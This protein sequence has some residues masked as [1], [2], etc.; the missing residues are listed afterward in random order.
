M[1][2]LVRIDQPPVPSAEGKAFRLWDVRAILSLFSARGVGSK[3][4]DTAGKLLIQIAAVFLA[5]LIA[6]KLGQATTN[7]R[8]SN[9]GPVWP[10]YG[11]ALAA[12]LAYGYRVW[13]G[14]AASAFLV[15]FA[16]GVTPLA[17][18]GQAIGATVAALT[19]ASLLR[20]IPD[21]DPSLLRLTDAL[22]LVVLGAFG[23]SI[24]SA[25][26]GVFSLYATHVQ[27]YSGLPSAWLIYWLGDSTGVLLVTPLVFTLPTLFG[28]RSRAH[29][30]ELA[31][32]ITLLTA[33]C[34]IVFGDLDVFP[35]RLH[36]LAFAVL[37]FVM[38][39]AI[40]F[41]IAGASLS[42]FLIATIATIATAY[43]FGPFAQSSSFSNAVLLDVLFAVLSVSGLVLG[44][45]IAERERAKSDREQLIRE[46]TAVETRVRLA[47]IIDSSHD[48]IFSKD[49]DGIVL[50]WNSAAQR[51]FGF[52]EAE[53]VGQP[54]AILLPPELED[55]E[56]RLFQR[57]RAGERIDRYK[58]M[59][60]TKA[61]RT[62][63]VSLTLTPL[64]DS[65]GR[66]VAVAEIARDVTEQDLAERAV[67]TLS[68]RLINAQEQERA[69]IA[70]ELH[71]DIGQR[72]ALLAIEL[73]RFSEAAP[74][75]LH[76]QVTHLKDQ[77]VGI[78]T[79]IQALA[80]ELHSSKLELLGI[81]TAME[82]FCH[83]F[84][85]Q[86][87]VEIDFATRDVPD[88]LPSDI[89]LCLFRVLQ[90]AL[91]NAAKHSGVLQF[92]VRLTGTADE[93][94]LVVSDTGKGFDLDAAKAGRGLGLVSMGERLKLVGGDVVIETHPGRGT[95]IHAG[96]PFAQEALRPDR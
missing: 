28:I 5:Y 50:S 15:A 43:G 20:R 41:G 87:H 34:F 22:G 54:G 1:D 96:A 49:L 68:S 57:F 18:A 2:I 58:T 60:V 80:H 24:I 93:I 85:D 94:H 39:A 66:L 19:G 92:E 67:S 77:A 55:E 52:S 10:A 23:S 35:I 76:G 86:T 53:V 7:I 71:D 90:E 95:R 30:V 75:R 14:I 32:L 27:A 88:D 61:G 46:Q 31:A 73:T 25:S 62:V 72:L 82:G 26:I 17:A 56:N 91:H 6:G 4:A 63:N 40:D 69:R 81:A 44:A 37:P 33:T 78:A 11:I 59:R 70:R 45:V 9:L 74:G 64:L 21:F 89:S 29:I 12:F 83:E 16:S 47:A 48:A 38:W 42:V 84:S 51:I 65:A 8:S 36:V 13:P 3:Q 79:G